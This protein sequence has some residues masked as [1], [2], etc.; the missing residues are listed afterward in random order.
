MKANSDSLGLAA[1]CLILL[2]LPMKDSFDLRCSTRLGSERVA[3]R[4][5]L[6]ARLVV[7]PE[8]LYECG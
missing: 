5:H 1:G 7:K 8:E 4:Y 3:E 6:K 2:Y